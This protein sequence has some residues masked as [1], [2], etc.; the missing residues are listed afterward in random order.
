MKVSLP[1]FLLFAKSGH[2][3]LVIFVVWIQIRERIISFPPDLIYMTT[4][5]TAHPIDSLLI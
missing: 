5:S 4:R 3:E 1:L 2:K